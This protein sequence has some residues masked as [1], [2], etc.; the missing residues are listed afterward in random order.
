[1]SHPL[2]RRPRVRV[3]RIRR[4]GGRRL[5]VLPPVGGGFRRPRPRLECVDAGQKLRMPRVALV[6]LHQHLSGL[7][8][9]GGFRE[10]LDQEAADHEQDVPDAESGLPVLGTNE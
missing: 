4:Q 10:R 1:M 7:L 3:R 8:V 9:E 2:R 5:P 6:I